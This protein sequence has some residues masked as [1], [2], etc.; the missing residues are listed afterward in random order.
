MQ[1]S[2]ENTKIKYAV[3]DLDGTLLDTLDDLTNSVN[4]VLENFGMPKRSRSD[5]RK[6]FGSG[7]AY[8]V[9]CAAPEGTN[10]EVISDMVALFRKHYNVHCMD[11]TRPYNGIPEMMRALA[12]R[13][14]KLAIV[15]NKIDSA[16]KELNKRFF[17]DCVSV[18]IGEKPGVKR[19][20]A[21][22]MVDAALA[23]LGSAGGDAVYIGDSE[24]DLLTAEN[25]GL[26]CIAVLWGFRDKDLLLEKG[27]AIFAETPADIIGLLENW[28]S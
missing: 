27:A 28:L 1:N 5:Y 19:K 7:I 20:P 17:A 2:H 24:V 16:V 12:A 11:N 14:Y 25:S 22:D 26:P 6:F 4:Y 3:F 21:R 15:S 10:E 23:E 13:G 9:R 18:A 8:A